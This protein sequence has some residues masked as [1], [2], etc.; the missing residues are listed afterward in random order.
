MA[1]RCAAAGA[2]GLRLGHPGIRS[3]ATLPAARRGADRPVRA[4]A[5]G[6]QRGAATPAAVRAPGIREGR[7]RHRRAGSP[8]AVPARLRHQP[9]RRWQLPGERRLDPGAVGG[10]LRAGRPASGRPRHPRPVRA[11]RAAARLAMGA[12]AT[13]GADR[14]G[15]RVGRGAGGGGAQSRHPLRDRVRPGVF[16][17]RAGL[18]PGGERGPGSARRQALDAVDGHTQTCRRGPAQGRRR[19]RRSA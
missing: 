3:G 11:D 12:G 2:V 5:R 18:P 17:E 1:P 16:G 19:V 4:T 10:G 6:D 13:A 14:R 7:A 15:P 9:R 8:S